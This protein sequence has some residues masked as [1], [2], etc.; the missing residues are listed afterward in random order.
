MSVAATGGELRRALA[1]RGNSP[2]PSGCSDVAQQ[3]LMRGPNY[4]GPNACKSARTH[5][6]SQ[7]CC[8]SRTPNSIRS[9]H[10]QQREDTSFQND[11]FRE[12]VGRS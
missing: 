2:P 8:A 5:M 12:A 3:L 9:D 7:I 4:S 6:E 10:M 11:Y 1:G